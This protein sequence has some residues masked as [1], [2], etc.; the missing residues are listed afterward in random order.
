[1]RIWARNR[2]IEHRLGAER[3]RAPEELVRM[4]SRR[5]SVPEPTPR[6]SVGPGVAVIAVVTVAIAA[7]LE[8]AGAVGYA[9]S[10][11]HTFGK[12]VEQIASAPTERGDE[13]GTN[14]RH[15]TNRPFEILILVP[16]PVCQD[17]SIRFVSIEEY[18]W[19]LLRGGHPAR[20]CAG[21]S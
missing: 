4:L 21:E 18:Y 7:S 8:A 20:F 13:A 3:P 2:G 12:N 9:T 15:G 17:G 1:V 19:I 5:F 10:S 6:R 16:V 11:L 14:E